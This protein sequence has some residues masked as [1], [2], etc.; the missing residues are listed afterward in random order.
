M[1]TKEEKFENFN[2]KASFVE[3]EELPTLDLTGLG[4][5]IYCGIEFG[6][7]AIKLCFYDNTLKP[8]GIGDKGVINLF[9]KDK[10]LFPKKPIAEKYGEHYFPVIKTAPAQK[11]R[12]TTFVSNGHCINYAKDFNT[13]HSNVNEIV[14]Q[15]KRDS[16]DFVQGGTKEHVELQ[17]YETNK[18]DLSVEATYEI[19]SANTAISIYKP[20]KENPSKILPSIKDKDCCIF[21]GGESTQCKNASGEYQ[22]F[23]NTD[24]EGIIGFLEEEVRA[25]SNLYLCS[26]AAYFMF[27]LL[28]EIRKD[29]SKKYIGNMAFYL[30][31]NSEYLKEENIKKK[32]DHIGLDSY[33][34][35]GIINIM[36]Q[37]IDLYRGEK[38]KTQNDPEE[39]HEILGYDLFHSEKFRDFIEQL[40]GKVYCFK[41]LKDNKIGAITGL[42]GKL[43]SQSAVQNG[44]Y[45]KASKSKKRKASKSKKRKASKSKK[46]KASKPKK[47]TKRKKSKKKSKKLN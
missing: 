41:G 15:I 36:K 10:N 16:N 44:G 22:S 43:A 30:D 6:S 28:Q 37:N 9:K 4:T 45:R 24:V 40:R 46:R 2:P 13:N 29:Q 7:S 12:F 38:Y 47:K 42:I 23:R 19:E 8:V 31:P 20:K 26:N 5:P 39:F 32:E 25:Q 21:I 1:A 35:K 27:A 3:E 11:V 34:F 18:Y 14:E 33:T 17:K